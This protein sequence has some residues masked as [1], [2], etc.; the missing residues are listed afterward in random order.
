MTPASSVGAQEGPGIGVAPQQ[1]WGSSAP[2]RIALQRVAPETIRR[3]VLRSVVRVLILVGGDLFA[4][5]GAQ[6]VVRALRDGVIFGPTVS[7]AVGWVVPRGSVAGWPLLTSLLVGLLL[8]GAYGKGD[9][10]R[11]PRRIFAGA[12]LAGGLTLWGALWVRGLPQVAVQF[13]GTVLGLWALVTIIRLVIDR[14]AARYWLRFQPG[15]RVV[16]IGDPNDAAAVSLCGRLARAERMETVGWITPPVEDGPLSGNGDAA[17]LGTAD[18]LWSILQHV[19]V[20]TV[21]MCGNLSDRMLGLI[22]EASAAAGCRLLSVSRYSGVG[23]LRPLLVSYH[24]L[25]FVELTVPA[26]RWPLRLVARLLEILRSGLALV[27]A[28][29]RSRFWR[30]EW[31]RSV[32]RS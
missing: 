31:A 23:R 7:D 20:D 5:V 19:D 4:F 32:R 6:A 21:L 3:H 18:N 16:F 22:V 2:A 14:G 10:R 13:T 9:D 28:L 27:P 26:L 12:A 15:E 8:A 17:A 29:K 11:D 25:P 30:G 1:A 24:G